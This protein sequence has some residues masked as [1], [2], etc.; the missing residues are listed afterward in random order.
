MRIVQFNSMAF[1]ALM[2]APYVEIDPVE[3]Y[4]NGFKKTETDF[5]IFGVMFS[6]TNEI[7][8]NHAPMR[9][10]KKARLSIKR[11]GTHILVANN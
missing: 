11:L 1:V 4:L 10:L 7:N 2:Q 8:K 6:K 5:D 3:L 9:T